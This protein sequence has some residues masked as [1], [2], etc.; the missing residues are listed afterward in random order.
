MSNLSSFPAIS[1]TPLDAI[2]HVLPSNLGAADAGIYLS[3]GAILYIL[4]RRFV[5]RQSTRLK[6]PP[7][8]LGSYLFGILPFL[9]NVPDV[10]AVFEGWA[11]QYGEVFS[12]P[13][14][15]GSR[16]IVLTDPR[17]IAHFSATETYSY[18]GTPPFKRFNRKLLGEGLFTSEGDSHKRQR[19]ALT[20]A[21]SN[22]A[23]KDMGPIFFDSAYKA[24]A[25]WDAMLE[26]E[27]SEAMIL[28]VQLW[29]NHISLDTIGLA[30]FSHDFGTLTGNI[31]NIASIFDAFGSQQSAW[32]IAIL[33]LSL[34]V[35][36]VDNL[37]TTR[38]TLFNQLTK[39]MQNLGREFMNNANTDK[40]IMGLLMKSSNSA[41]ISQ[42]EVMSQIKFLLVAGYE[43][44][45][46]SLTWALVELCRNPDIQTKLR[47]ELLCSGDPTWEELTA[48]GSY[49]D[50]FT[51]EIMRMHPPLP[52]IERMAAQ[53]DFLPLSAPIQTADG[54]FVNEV[55][56]RKGQYVKLSIDCINRSEK[57]WGPDAKVFNPARWIDESNG[58][59]QQ[60]AKELQGYR[61][62]LTFS[63]GP[64]ICLGKVFALVEFK[65][66]IS[67]LVRNF[68]FEFPNGPDT[69]IT[70][71]MGMLP[72][73]G[74]A[75]EAGYDVPLR[76]RHY[77]SY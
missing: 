9:R 43:T 11:A 45:A 16:T 67:V 54:D 6:G 55:L 2:F 20:P 52:E 10:G 46:I 24:K 77:Q 59:D 75:G 17:A 19:R 72:R 8:T 33:L 40:S 76:I 70:R 44:T 27:P 53:D 35:P 49:L 1:D 36:A 3:S 34:I 15:L 56:V 51:C 73:P 71:R 74:V 25:A 62:L 60:R 7:T 61:H 13:G 29:M 42:E 30:G 18:I 21:F 63:D 5:R 4:W 31:S 38:Q 68:T 50:A 65:T 47:N 12:V 14:I 22:V 57:L 39:E 41:T 28:E 23:V 64:R 32:D 37:P 26:A 58:V 66:V 48:Y 69:E